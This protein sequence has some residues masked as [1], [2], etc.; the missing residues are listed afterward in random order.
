MTIHFKTE[1]KSDRKL[2][3]TLPPDVPIGSVEVAVTITPQNGSPKRP[4]TSLADWA[5]ANAE[6]WG[7]DLDSRDREGFA[8][9]RY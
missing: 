8:G 1:L 2:N 9:R 3:L 6:N 7:D 5:D 4:R